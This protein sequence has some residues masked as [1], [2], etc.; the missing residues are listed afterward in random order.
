MKQTHSVLFI[1]AKQ[2]VY[3]HILQ[4]MLRRYGCVISVTN[5]DTAAERGLLN[6]EK[7]QMI[8]IFEGNTAP[9][10][11]PE[12]TQ[13]YLQ[14]GGKL[15]IL[16]APPFSQ[17][18]YSFTPLGG[19]KR[20]GRSKEQLL[21]ALDHSLFG[22]KTLL[23]FSDPAILSQFKKD[24]ANPDS[25]K[26]EGN[27]VLSIEDCPF[28]RKRCLKWYTPDFYINENF[29]I[30]LTIPLH[31]DALT[32]CAKADE[33]TRTITLT[34]IQKNGMTFKTTFLPQ[35]DWQR[36]MFM[37]KDFRFA[38]MLPGYGRPQQIPT[39]NFSNVTAIRIG[40]AASHA[41][42]CA[43][44]HSFYIDEIAAAHI[45]FADRPQ[46]VI[47][48]I[49]PEYKF[50]PVTNAARLVPAKGQ[51]IINA[52]EKLL[53]PET[54]ITSISPLSQSSGLDKHRRFRFIPL[55]EL[56]DAHRLHCGYAAYMLQFYN[57]SCI[58]EKNGSDRP[59]RPFIDDFK[60][61]NGGMVS[62][63]TPSDN[64]FY[65]HG[66]CNAVCAAA[67]YMLR[68]VHLLEGGSREYAYFADSPSAKAG[69]V[70]AVDKDVPP[71]EL[72]DFALTISGC[73]IHQTLK[74]ADLPVIG[75]D[76]KGKY[77]LRR[78][79]LDFTAQNGRICC[80][81]A[82]HN[83]QYDRI[84][85]EVQLYEEKPEK[86][87]RF[88]RIAKDGECEIEIGGNI[89][90]FFGV[91]YMPSGCI[92]NE[93]DAYHEFYF[94]RFAY[95]PE[96]V[97]TDLKRIA[98]I[99]MNA[100]SVFIYSHDCVD[101]LNFLHFIA[102]CREYG[103]YID[104]GLR[105]HATPFQFDEEET[106]RMIRALRLSECDRIVAYDIS[107]ERYNGTYEP[108]Y[109][110]YFGRKS[111]DAAFREYLLNRFGS[112]ESA[113]AFVGMK[114]P[115][116]AS[117]EVIGASDEMLRSDGEHRRFVAVYRHFVD[118][119]V[120]RA[121]YR[122][123]Q[124]IKQYDPNHLLTARTGDASTIPLVDPG[125]YGYDYRCLAPGLDFYSPEGYALSEKPESLRQAV[126]TNE[127][128]RF[129]NPNAVVQ[130]KEFGKSIWCG[131]NFTDNTIGKEI[132]ADFYRKFF[133]ML[134]LAHTSGV[135][136]WWWSGGYRIGEN[137]DFGVINPDG[138]DRAVTRVLREYA[139]KFLQAPL[140]QKASG[141]VAFDRS[142]N[143][144]GLEHGY[145]KVEEAFFAGWNQGERIALCNAG[146]GKTTRTIERS[147]SP[148]A[149]GAPDSFFL[150]WLSEEETVAIPVFNPSQCVWDDNVALLLMD[151]NRAIFRAIPLQKPVCLTG[152]A[153]FTVSKEDF[154]HA[155]FLT[156]AADS[157]PFG[158]II[159]KA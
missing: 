15:I 2:P 117:G 112:F 5:W 107:W 90:R 101:N 127:Y 116:N 102:L 89:T 153:V 104:L 30:P 47:P 151:E 27:A 72:S 93:D 51:N 94:S 96:I 52:N 64:L 14:R 42:S 36:Y 152:S 130:W 83:V 133:D 110:N 32:F 31:Y 91:N 114:L 142:E 79:E 77:E 34:L 1:T 10:R 109:G 143:S 78:A 122:A 95:D 59:T 7:F 23:D 55:I 60:R 74:V 98:A 155:R 35:T 22:T 137:S 17:D 92:G 145:Q 100:V 40:H 3:F 37:S 147:L 25:K 80:L 73:G 62:V 123:A 120:R 8:I 49:Y 150:D 68:K 53:M 20:T 9:V 38:G 128:S 88:A 141:A 39:V 105:L 29:E 46:T 45:P 50:Y 131:S 115:R 135:Y 61:L 65:C 81:L 21:Q 121:H 6:P 63:F 24:T 118:A 71:E 146:T 76:R 86:E 67:V 97:R 54:G 129:Y 159:R 33:K 136:A 18:I 84:E 139:P 103:L 111:Y 149:D 126:F 108:C 43:G 154:A 75:E 11:A 85:C 106:A 16:G 158:E 99:G 119:H 44:E 132:Q 57:D 124:K 69:A 12:L 156:L 4:A 148:D 19:A 58:A 82:Q 144:T 70:V 138:S 28:A 134:L 56:L 48:G 113:E 66:G 157:V 26:Y 87:R 13:S 140:L 125:I 41:Y